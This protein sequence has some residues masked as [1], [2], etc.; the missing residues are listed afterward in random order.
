MDLN[1]LLTTKRLG[2]PTWVWIAGVTAIGSF[3]VLKMRSAKTATTDTGTSAQ[4]SQSA[5][6]GTWSTSTTGTNGD[7][8]TS[9]FSGPAYSPGFL[10]TDATM[11]LQQQG[12]DT[13]INGVPPATQGPNIPD[14]VA[15]LPA[16]TY[17]VTGKTTPSDQY[18]GGIAIAAY[19]IAKG[20]DGYAISP[21]AAANEAFE[22]IDM[23]LLNPGVS[24]PIP[25]GTTVK[26]PATATTAG[27]T[28]HAYPQTTSTTG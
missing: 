9:T 21:N 25:V 24:Q 16:S 28:I 1:A 23:Q 12:G 17:T 18:W 6:T 27:P 20:S 26:V 11:P 10:S 5:G 8:S 14:A 7:T 15:G 22:M 19:N 13:Y 4:G 3:I 2:A